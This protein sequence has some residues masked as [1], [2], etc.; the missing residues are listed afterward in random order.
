VIDACTSKTD[1]YDLPR[2]ILVLSRK[3]MLEAYCTWEAFATL[4]MMPKISMRQVI[5]DIDNIEA[6]AVCNRKK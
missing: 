1:T 4:K 6:L 3:H 2:D 5:L